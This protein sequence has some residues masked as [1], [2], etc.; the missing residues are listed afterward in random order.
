MR[1]WV[2]AGAALLSA[3]ATV[4]PVPSTPAVVVTARAETVPVGTAN[5]DAADDPAIWRNPAD[6]AQ[7][8]IVATDKKAG[9]YVYGLDG[10]RR[11]F[12]GAG[13]LNNVDLLDLDD[14][15]VLVAASDRNDIAN[16]KI[17]LYRLDTATAALVPL[18][19][20]TGGTGEGYGLCLDRIGPK[21]VD[22]F[23]VLK[24]GTVAQVRID[25][26]DA[27]PSGA[28]VRTLKIPTQ[29][30]GCVVDSRT[31]RLFV[32]EEAAG[33]WQF[34]SRAEGPATGTLVARVDGQHLVADV[35][36]LAI[37]ADAA[38]TGYLIASSQGDNAYALFRLT[39][40]APAGRFRIGRS[41]FGATEETDG[42]AVALGGFGPKFPGGL[43]VA[44]DGHNAPAAQ[45]FKLAAWADI[46]AALGGPNK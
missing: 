1:A 27:A 14:G 4:P 9:L 6:P 44:Q 43:F 10:Q 21:S 18:G 3:C 32:G 38:G 22:A 28:I 46:L 31:H 45:N 29:T 34:D 11:G 26:S 42:I 7:S 8:L 17:R 16:A 40:L 33:I 41:A 30:E 35:E 19:T 5:A 15:F 23:S 39:D 12:D 37:A 25:L 2:L 36:G 24:D 20:V 13:L